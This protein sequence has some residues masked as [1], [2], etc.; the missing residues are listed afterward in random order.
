MDILI[1][2]RP[3]GYNWDQMIF[4]MISVLEI[5]QNPDKIESYW[6]KIRDFD[7]HK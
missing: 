5:K 7:I 4:S 6:N 2:G 1:H 3:C